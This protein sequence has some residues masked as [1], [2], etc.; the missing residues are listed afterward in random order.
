MPAERRRAYRIRRHCGAPSGTCLTRMSCAPM[1]KAYS[2]S[3]SSEVPPGTITGI[4]RAPVGKYVNVRNPWQS[5]SV[6]RMISTAGLAAGRVP[7][8][9]LSAICSPRR[10]LPFRRVAVSL[11]WPPASCASDRI[12]R[13]GLRFT[14]QVWMFGRSMTWEVGSAPFRRKLQAMEGKATVLSQKSSI[15]RMAWKNRSK[16]TGLRM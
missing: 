7:L 3:M 12:R 13:V 8:A 10:S 4:C 5:D 1:R 15:F 11:A 14:C 6:N 16:S 9:R 2:P